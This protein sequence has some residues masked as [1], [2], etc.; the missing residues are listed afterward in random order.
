MSA[1]PQDC[2]L[3][4]DAVELGNKLF[5]LQDKALR[6]FLH[7]AAAAVAVSAIVPPAV[8]DQVQS[9]IQTGALGTAGTMGHFRVCKCML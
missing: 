1:A 3:L 5:R 2:L 4:Q 7:D 9:A 6:C 8:W